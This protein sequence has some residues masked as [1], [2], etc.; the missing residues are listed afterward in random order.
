M[1][2]FDSNDF[3]EGKF[4]PHGRLTVWPDDNILRFDVTGPMN[5]EAISALGRM[6]TKLYKE[7]SP[8][9]RSF[10]V[11]AVFH[12]SMLMPQEALDLFQSDLRATYI[13]RLARP[14]AVAWVAGHDVEGASVMFRFVKR[15]HNEI[16]TECELFAEQNSAEAW[17][18]EKMKAV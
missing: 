11:L 10:C 16:E 15:L 13:S 17:L 8:S 7:F 2:T 18:N 5:L 9:D 4:S 3:V 12:V 14:R 1:A 6:R